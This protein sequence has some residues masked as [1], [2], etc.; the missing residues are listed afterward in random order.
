MRDIA[1]KLVLKGGTKYSSDKMHHADSLPKTFWKTKYTMVIVSTNNKRDQNSTLVTFLIKN[2]MTAKC[3]NITCEALM[4]IKK[5]SSCSFKISLELGCIA[6]EFVPLLCC[7]V[8]H[9]WLRSWRVVY[10][11]SSRGPPAAPRS[12]EVS[13][14]DEEYL[15][16]RTSLKGT[17]SPRSNK[18][19]NDNVARS[20]PTLR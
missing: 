4:L 20:W 8:D 15:A 2:L 17:F 12:I 5:S 11:T 18:L 13:Q 14:V 16:E 10:F 1:A 6:K 9:P 19:I 7:R 3:P